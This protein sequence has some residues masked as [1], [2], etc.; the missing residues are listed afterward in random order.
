[1]SLF[2][3]QEIKNDYPEETEGFTVFQIERIWQ[4][5]SDSM[6]AGWLKPSKFEVEQVFRYF[7]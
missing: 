2:D 6:C 1:M 5:H 7:R 4:E 3:A